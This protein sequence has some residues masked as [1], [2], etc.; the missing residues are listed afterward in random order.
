MGNVLIGLAT[1]VKLP[2]VL[3]FALPVA[4]LLHHPPPRELKYVGLRAIILP[5]CLA[6]AAAWYLTVIPEWGGNP[7]IGGI[8]STEADW[9]RL[10]DYLQHNL[11]STLPEM[12]LGFAALPAFLYGIYAAVRNRKHLWSHYRY[13]WLLGVGLVAFF[14][15]ELNALGKAHDYY[16]YPYLP[17]IFLVVLY[18]CHNWYVAQ[19][20]RAVWFRLLLPLLFVFAPLACFLRLGHAWSTEY[21]GYNPD[22]YIHRE[23]LRSAVPDGT[24]VIV[25]I[26]QSPY[27]YLYHLR[28]YGWT[29]NSAQLDQADFENMLRAGAAYLYIDNNQLLQAPWVKSYLEEKVAEAGSFKV[30]RL[31]IPNE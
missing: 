21:A 1:L 22:L 28:K 26:D 19:E 18:G 30:Y 9:L 5:L 29:L 2:F 20:G 27:I 4:G 24:P 12:L 31:T 8:L 16:L 11:I 6:P 15:Y 7:V 23:A 25:G 14:L 3:L 17:V 13:F 10:A